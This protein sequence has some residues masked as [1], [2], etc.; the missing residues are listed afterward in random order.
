MLFRI[1]RG[2]GWWPRDLRHAGNGES[3][4]EED[5]A[6]LARSYPSPS[7][8]PQGMS[9]PIVVALSGL[10]CYFPSSAVPTFGVPLTEVRR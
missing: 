10:T 7:H 5:S 3:K 2:G 6:N 9:R 1:V 8:R 4:R